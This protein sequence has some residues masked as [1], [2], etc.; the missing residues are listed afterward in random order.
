MA[1]GFFF[2][3]G[4]G[5]WPDAAGDWADRPRLKCAC[6]FVGAPRDGGQGSDV[7]VMTVVSSLVFFGQSMSP[8]VLDGLGRVIG[9]TSSRF[10]FILLATSYCTFVPV[11]LGYRFLS[12]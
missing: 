8:I 7:P 12:Y 1:F 4:G 6:Y 11:S 2:E 9:D 5:I 10:T 3:S